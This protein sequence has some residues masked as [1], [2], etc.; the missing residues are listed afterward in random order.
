MA[1]KIR[2][3]RIGT[4]NK[5]MYRIVVVDERSKRDGKYLEEVGFYNPLINPPVVQINDEVAL[6]WLKNGACTTKR[7]YTLFKKQGIL[8]RLSQLKRKSEGGN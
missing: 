5:P 2:L 1:V 4:T 6:K 7:V 8:D 3:R